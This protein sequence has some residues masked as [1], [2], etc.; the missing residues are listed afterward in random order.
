MK[1]S[2]SDLH[3]ALSFKN[4]DGVQYAV[5]GPPNADPAEHYKATSFG[6]STTCAPIPQGSCQVGVPITNA[7][8]GQGSP[9]MLIPFACNKSSSGI[10]I[11][12]NLTSHNTVTNML[13]FHEYALESA[14][15]MSNAMKTPNDL[16]D[17]EILR[18]LQNETADD[19]FRNPWSVLALRK[20][21]FATQA[22]FDRL[23]KPF[24]NDTRIWKHNLLGA[25]A[26]M[27][28]NVTGW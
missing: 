20:I 3:K 11:V 28:C 7:L 10:D 19:V 13:N 8:D 17:A 12:G 2:V 25:F 9:V 22:D 1:N 15:F 24:L 16:T 23:P 4:T 18:A 27:V 5:V 21:P 6:V 26:L 14:P